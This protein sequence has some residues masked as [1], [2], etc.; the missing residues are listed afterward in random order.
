MK[1]NF[2]TK[3][4]VGISEAGIGLVSKGNA[5][6]TGKVDDSEQN[7]SLQEQY[8]N[9]YN[10]FP[11]VAAS[12][13][14]TAEEVV[15]DYYFEGPNSDKL[16]EFADKFNLGHKFYLIAKLL[17]KNGNAWVEFPKSGNGQIEDVKI[18]DP[19]Y[20][21]T[22]RY[23]DGEVIGHTQEGIKWKILWGKTGST[24]KNNKYDKSGKLKDIVHFKF[25]ALHNE[26][27]GNSIIHPC[28][29]LLKIKDRIESDT[30]TIVTRYAAPIMHVKVG[31]ENHLPSDDDIENVKTEV[32][33]IYSDTEYVTN[34]FTEITPLGFEGKAMRLG[35]LMERVDMNIISGLQTPAVLID[36]GS[37][38][39]ES[40]EVQLRK[41]GRH[42]K[43]IQRILK[44]EFEDKVIVGQEIGTKKDKLMWGSVE[45]REE[46]V[47]FDI[48]RGLVKDGLIT[49]QKANSLLPPDYN[50]ELPEVVNPPIGG[51]GNPQD[52]TP[53]QKG[54][55]KVK[56]NPN[57][58]KKIQRNEHDVV[59]NRVKK[60]EKKVPI[61]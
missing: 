17:L 50:E 57:N 13:D 37:S 26:K 48:L 51:P 39:T 34:P 9:A 33:D 36:M 44:I 45:E 61:K 56:E 12:I 35:E 20:M 19:L 30:K 14:T 47:D 23:V 46:E 49:P 2:F 32:K 27:Y 15:Q 60:N 40:A 4:K 7:V 58:P 11:V 42:V 8:N 1:L 41:F 21:R 31:D 54:G 28:L 29:P 38:S 53:F 52:Q 18:L 59:D 5:W 43:A 25:N 3:P 6:N 22:W 10:N 24:S 55:D 16:D